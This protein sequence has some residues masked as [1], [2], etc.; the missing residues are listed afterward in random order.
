[1]TNQELLKELRHYLSG[2]TTPQNNPLPARQIIEGR[3]LLE[4]IK[5]ELNTPTTPWISASVLLP[6]KNC[7]AFYKNSFGKNRIV[8]AFYA[9]KFQLEQS[10]DNSYQDYNEETDTYFL[11]EGWYETIDNWPDFS[12]I[13]ITEGEVTH[14]MVLPDAPENT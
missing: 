7:L 5:S 3:Y 2:I 4:R 9:K 13:E 1:M 14:W 8:K 6:D 10:P 11:P 12:Y